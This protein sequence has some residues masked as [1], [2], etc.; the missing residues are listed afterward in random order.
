MIPLDNPYA[1]RGAA[2]LGEYYAHGLAQ[3]VPLRLRS[4]GS[5]SI[6]AGDVGS[7]TWEEVDPHSARPH[8]YQFPYI[9]GYTAQPLYP[10]PAAY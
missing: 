6:W 3:P 2:A 7:T 1:T 10:R 4:E 5:H 9:E 8:N